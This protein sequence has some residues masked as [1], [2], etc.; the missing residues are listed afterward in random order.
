M[1]GS[2]IFANATNIPANVDAPAGIIVDI[3]QADLAIQV[4]IDRSQLPSQLQD[5]RAIVSMRNAQGQ[6]VRPIKVTQGDSVTFQKGNLPDGEYIIKV[7]VR[8]FIE[9]ASFTI[10]N[11]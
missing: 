5:A 3:I 7:R 4:N 9:T 1:V 8:K 10:G 2:S 11:K 6:P